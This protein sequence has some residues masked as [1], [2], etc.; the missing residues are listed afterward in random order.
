LAQVL[1]KGVGKTK[2]K[3]IALIGE[4]GA[5][6]TT[7]LQAIAFRILDKNLGLP[8]WISLA[9]LQQQDGNLEDFKKYL[10]QK[11]LETAI[12]ETRLT[13]DI[14]LILP[15]NMNLGACGCCWMGWMR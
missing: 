6:K 8:I 9:D 4:P 15:I 13:Q 12:P 3:R 11:W 7:L 10:L 2:G 1:E 5:G 14:K